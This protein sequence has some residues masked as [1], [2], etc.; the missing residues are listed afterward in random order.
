MAGVRHTSSLQ[1]LMHESKPKR[2][3]HALDLMAVSSALGL[4]HKRMMHRFSSKKH[5]RALSCDRGFIGRLNI[6]TP[7]CIAQCKTTAK[8]VAALQPG[9]IPCLRLWVGAT[10]AAAAVADVGYGPPP[11]A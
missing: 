8:T 5:A 1:R 3:L 6:R 2:Q 11:A 7:E 9:F 4:R 10:A